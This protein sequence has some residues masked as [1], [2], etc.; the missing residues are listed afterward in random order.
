MKIEPVGPVTNQTI[1]Y[2]TEWKN[3][4]DKNVLTLHI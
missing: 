2:Q 1:F 4:S 3:F